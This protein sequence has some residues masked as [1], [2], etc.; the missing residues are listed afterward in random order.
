M[1]ANTGIATD[2]ARQPRQSMGA[3]AGETLSAIVSSTTHA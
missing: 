2:S 1:Y 3:M